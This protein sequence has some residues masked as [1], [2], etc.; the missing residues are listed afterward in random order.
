MNKKEIK[1]DLAEVKKA[2]FIEKQEKFEK[3]LNDLQDEYG[4]FLYPANVVLPNQ[5]VR[6]M[7]KIMEKENED[8]TK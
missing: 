1:V 7:I 6:P 8:N 2:K 5:E 4:L 3:K